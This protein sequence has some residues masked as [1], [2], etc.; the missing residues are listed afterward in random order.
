MGELNPEKAPVKKSPSTVKSAPDLD[1]ILCDDGIVR[2]F[3]Q[4]DGSLVEGVNS[5]LKDIEGF[6]ADKAGL[7]CDA[8]ASGET[9]TKAL[10][11]AGVSRASHRRWL[12]NYDYRSMIDEARS[13]RADIVHEKF[14]EDEIKNIPK[15][16]G[17]DEEHFKNLIK[18][19]KVVSAFKQEDSPERYGV[20][21]EKKAVK[22]TGDY[23]LNLTIDDKVL[24]EVKR[25][26]T[27]AL[28]EEGEIILE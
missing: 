9:H 13:A 20:K 25:R 21:H 26:F 11:I 18:K 2:G 15:A 14:Y 7:Y 3:S 1:Y 10:E 24:D 23:S 12:K 17:T 27:P 19:Q 28:N 4:E 5:G 6:R 22:T 16:E 8:L